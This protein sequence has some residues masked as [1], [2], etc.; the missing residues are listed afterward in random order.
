MPCSEKNDDSGHST[1]G[2]W[3][4]VV[5][6]SGDELA[7]HVTEGLLFLIELRFLAKVMRAQL[8]DLILQLLNLLVSWWLTQPRW[9]Q[10]MIQ[11]RCN[12]L[13]YINNRM[14]SVT[15]ICSSLVTV[16]TTQMVRYVCQK[17]LSCVYNPSLAVQVTRKIKRSGNLHVDI[18]ATFGVTRNSYSNGRKRIWSNRAWISLQTLAILIGNFHE[19]PVPTD[20]CWEFLKIC[21]DY[22]QFIIHNNSL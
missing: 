1:D 14:H 15:N 6:A 13:Q 5:P 20:K 11:L 2:I 19:F 4:H 7:P 18:L 16:R 8:E 22:F 9:E 17:Y 12:K 10:L 21:H 3:V